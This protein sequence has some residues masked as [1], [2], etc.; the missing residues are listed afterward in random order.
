M[1][2][3]IL[4]GIKIEIESFI[5]YTRTLIFGCWYYPYESMRHADC[6]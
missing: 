5:M 4:G 2:L 1:D 6:I 3:T